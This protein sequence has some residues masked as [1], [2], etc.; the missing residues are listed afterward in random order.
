MFDL[1]GDPLVAAAV[2]AA[3][4]GAGFAFSDIMDAFFGGRRMG[5]R[6]RG[7]RPGPPR[8]GRAGPARA[9]PGRDRVRRHPR[10]HRRHRGR[11]P[12]LRRRGHRAGH[13]SGDLPDLQRPGRDPA[14]Q[15]SFLG[16]VMTSRP[17]P[18]CARRRHGD[19]PTRARS[20]P[21]TAGSGPRRTI[22]VDPAGVDDGTRIRLAGEGEVGPGGG[23]AGDL[24]VEISERPHAH[25]H[26]RGQ[27]P[28]LHG[29]AADDGG[30]ARHHPAGRRRLDGPRDVDI[31]PGTQSGQVISLYGLGTAQLNDS[32][33]GDLIIH[34]TVETPAK[35]DTDQENLLRQLAKLRG[36]EAPPGKFGPWA[37][38]LL[39]PAAR[40]V[41]RALTT[42]LTERWP[43]ERI[44]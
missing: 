3:R 43:R 36:E 15:R 22:K 42:Y 24:Y 1:G 30:R 44:R 13:P 23:P 8:P 5:Q 21:A 37:A 14:V 10:A 12:D 34:V 19:P 39:F 29:H 2:T 17:C 18:A 38:G 9:R 41:Q 25:V 35:L 7:P 20:A 16:Q 6:G 40:C 33:R 27:R 31:R 26:P 32:G 28:A 11:L 4:R